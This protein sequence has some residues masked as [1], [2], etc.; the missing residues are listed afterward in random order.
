MVL[1]PDELF[2]AHGYSQAPE[3]SVSKLFWLGFLQFFFYSSIAHTTGQ[4]CI[5]IEPGKYIL[6]RRKMCTF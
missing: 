2:D 5:I 6:H 4:K 1:D 3:L